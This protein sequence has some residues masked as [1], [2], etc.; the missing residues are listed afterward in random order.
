MDIGS[1]RF[2]FGAEQIRSGFSSMTD[3]DPDKLKLD[4][5]RPGR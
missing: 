5:F 2:Y 4:R 1:G 3:A